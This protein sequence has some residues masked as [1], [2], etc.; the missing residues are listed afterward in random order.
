MVG[1]GATPGHVAEQIQDFFGDP[2]AARVEKPP[3]LDSLSESGERLI[4]RTFYI[5][6][7]SVFHI[8]QD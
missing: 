3:G 1:P 5:R 7:V 4:D 2:P 6:H 8:R